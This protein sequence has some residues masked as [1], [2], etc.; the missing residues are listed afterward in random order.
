MQKFNKNLK[1]QEKKIK[2]KTNAKNNKNLKIQ[3]KK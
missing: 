2:F 3:E 1:I